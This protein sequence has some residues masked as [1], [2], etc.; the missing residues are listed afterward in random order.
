MAEYSKTTWVAGT[1]PC[2]Q[3]NMNNLE[4]Q[5]DKIKSE[6]LT[7]AGVKTFDS[8]PVLPATAP[9]GNEAV[10]ASFIL[11]K[12]GN[13]IASDT[14]L[15]ANDSEKTTIASTYV[16]LKQ[17]VV[18]PGGILRIKFS[19]KASAGASTAYGKIYQNGVAVGTEQTNATTNY[20]EFSEDISGWGPGDLCQIYVRTVNGTYTAY[21]KNF[22]IYGTVSEPW[23]ASL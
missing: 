3:D 8:K 6:T 9:T 11:T 1:T 7:F 14:L 12:M 16:L 20:V 15:S 2:S 17:T 19:I 4:T 23:T 18:G 22:R 10:P 21:V 5:Y 13:S